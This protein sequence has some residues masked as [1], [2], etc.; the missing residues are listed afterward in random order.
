[1]VI[2]PALDVPPLVLVG[3]GLFEPPGRG[4]VVVPFV[5]LVVLDVPVVPVSFFEL[6]V[7]GVVPVVH[8]LEPE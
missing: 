2:S 7:E 1:M 6:V 3:L 4:L 5:V 8:E